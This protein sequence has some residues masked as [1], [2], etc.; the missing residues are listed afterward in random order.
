MSLVYLVSTSKDGRRC[1]F[2]NTDARLNKYQQPIQ[3]PQFDDENSKQVTLE[4]ALDARERWRKDFG[5][6]VQ[7]TLEKYGK[8]FDEDHGIAAP[9]LTERPIEHPTTHVPLYGG[10]F[11]GKGYFIHYS[12][13]RQKFYCRSID[14]PSM[15]AEHRDRETLWADKPEDVANKILELWGVKIAVPVEDPEA[16]EREQFARQQEQAAQKRN[17][18]PRNIRPG[19][20]G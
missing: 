5:I 6:N 7:I 3:V 11:D 2:V 16:I 15:I 4:F 18:T 9:A 10:G 12:P 17:Q 19:D 8:P 20:R 1:W 13:E 14:I